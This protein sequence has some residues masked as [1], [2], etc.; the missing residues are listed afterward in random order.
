MS[1]VQCSNHHYYD[2][3][4]NNCCPLCGELSQKALGQDNQEELIAKTRELFTWKTDYSAQKMVAVKITS[5]DLPIKHFLWTGEITAYYNRING[6]RDGGLQ[7]DDDFFEETLVKLNENENLQIMELLCSIDF[8]QWKTSQRTIELVALGAAGFCPTETFECEFENGERFWFYPSYEDASGS[9]LHDL[10][11]SV[12]EIVKPK[13]KEYHFSPLSETVLIEE[14]EHEERFCASCGSKLRENA[15]FCSVCGKSMQE[16]PGETS[17]LCP[18]CHG[19]FHQSDNYCPDCGVNV[20]YFTD[21]EKPQDEEELKEAVYAFE[22]LIEAHQKDEKDNWVLS[23]MLELLNFVPLFFAVE[24]DTSAILG[25][26]NPLSLKPGDTLTLQQNV[27][28]K[29][30]TYTLVDTEVIPAFTKGA[31]ADTSVMRFYPADYIDMLIGLNKPLVINLMQDYHF[32]VPVHY[33]EH[34]KQSIQQ[35]MH[36]PESKVCPGCGITISPNDAENLNFCPQCGAQLE[37]SLAEKTVQEDLSIG[38]IIGGRYE[39]MSVLPKRA[40]G[41]KRYLLKD[42]YMQK[43]WETVEEPKSSFTLHL[44]SDT[45]KRLDYP[46]I[47]RIADMIEQDENIY[48]ICEYIEGNTL[49]EIVK[50]YGAQPE[51]LVVNW[52][53]QVAGVLD[54]LYHFSPIIIHRDIKPQLLVLHPSGKLYVTDFSIARVYNPSKPF[55]TMA[56]GTVGYAAP[57]QY[58]NAQTDWRTDI[59]GLGM[60]LFHILTGVS[61]VKKDVKILPVRQYDAHISPGM[62]YIV[63]KCIQLD[64]NLRYQTPAQLLYDLEHITELPPKKGWFKRKRR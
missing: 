37:S 45:L 63:E 49:F 53:K 18:V 50:E 41:D 28:A 27:K 54:Y 47:P 55:D 2:D 31:Y 11:R 39:I 61:P 16:N 26:I 64:P 59:F 24:I 36:L 13:W 33:F 21:I 62:E 46:G 44:N 60:T 7:F 38:K 23:K 9:Q 12:E 51:Y 56:L 29:I 6:S 35:K 17:L 34:M 5:G 15:R 14:Q 20:K 19:S 43:L 57:E 58:G 32:V 10:F 1:I 25:D 8:S 42:I 22:K 48:L 52:A 3:E 30:L 4:K 40:T